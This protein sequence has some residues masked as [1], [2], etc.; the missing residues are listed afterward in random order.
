MSATITGGKEI[1]KIFNA[2]KGG[3][4]SIDIGVFA[5]SKYFDGT[6]VAY[7]AMLNEFGTEDELGKVLIPERP[8]IRIAN[9]ENEKVL[10]QIIKTNIDPKLMIITKQLAGLLGASQQLSLIHI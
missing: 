9:K 8:A 4:K 3:V 5:S 7:V 10:L 1:Q 6:Q 2:G